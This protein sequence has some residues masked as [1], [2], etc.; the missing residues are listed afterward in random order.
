MKKE[1]DYELIHNTKFL[2]TKIVSYC[3][4][5]TDFQDKEI[6]KAVSNYNCLAVS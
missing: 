1:L 4:E 5:A 6:T 3:D 2:K